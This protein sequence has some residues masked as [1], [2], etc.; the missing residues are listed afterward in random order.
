[1]FQF[2][3]REVYAVLHDFYDMRLQMKPYKLNNVLISWEGSYSS[4]KKTLNK[5]IQPVKIAWKI[6][7]LVTW[8]IS[9]WGSP[10]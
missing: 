1:M 2:K 3:L 8:S 10:F 6:S 5:E 7:Y 9:N 4:S